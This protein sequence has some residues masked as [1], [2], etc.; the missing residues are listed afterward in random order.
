MSTACVELL[1]YIFKVVSPFLAVAEYC[2]NMA[3]KAFSCS[4]AP[5]LLVMRNRLTAATHMVRAVAPNSIILPETICRKHKMGDS[6]SIVIL[7][8]SRNHL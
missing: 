7:L 1:K 3:A 2:P 5:A 4:D 8:L 6:V